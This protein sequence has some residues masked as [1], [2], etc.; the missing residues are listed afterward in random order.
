MQQFEK[1]SIKC[2]KCKCDLEFLRL[3]IIYCPTTSFVKINLWKKRI[4]S[5]EQYLSFQY[6]CLKT[7]Y[8]N[9][10][11][12]SIKYEKEITELVEY[13]KFKM[14]Y[15]DFHLLQKFL[16]KISEKANEKFIKANEKKLIK[17]NHGPISQERIG[18][19]STRK[20][21]TE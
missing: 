17:L 9:R 1:L 7:K 18:K 4:K 15:S 19:L 10:Y 16:H 5:T 14:C 3:C 6:F 20:I 2:Q 21:S 11:K 13:L 8:G 12:G